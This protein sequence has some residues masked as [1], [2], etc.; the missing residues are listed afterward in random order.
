MFVQVLL[1][2]PVFIG[3]AVLDL[4][5]LVMYQLR[6]KSLADYA[7]RFG[8][9]IT[10]A[11]GDTDSFF[12]EVRDISLKNHL[13][14]AMAKDG[15]LDTSNLPSS[16]PLYSN[17]NK[18]RLGC[19]KDE[20]AG[21]VWKEWVLLRP[22]CYSMITQSEHEHKRAK[23]VQRSV[24][25]RAMQHDS[26]VAIFEGAEADYRNVRRFSS[27]CHAIS[28]VE[29]R[30]KA[31]SLWEDKRAW[32]SL[33]SSLAYGHHSLSDSTAPLPSPPKRP[34]FTIQNLL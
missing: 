27:V 21:E 6:Y 20:G 34:R 26:Y 25:A 24:V 16:H 32:T 11:G 9:S 15:L 14:P 28:T 18:A 4:S 31:L 29:Q 2:K 3:Q 22:K 19:V 30:K 5:K 13:L 10:I 7:K 1:D 17:T 23:G 12:L 33:N 8:G